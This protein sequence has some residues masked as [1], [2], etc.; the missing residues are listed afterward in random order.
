MPS[1]TDY[2]KSTKPATSQSAPTP[3][4]PAPPV[5]PEQS[6]TPWIEKFRP[7]KLDD[8]ACQEETIR[9]L[10]SSLESN[11]L[12]HLLFYGP[13][14]TGKTSTILAVARELYG[15]ELMKKRVLEL[16]ASDERG[17]SVVREKV[18]TF[19]QTAVGS[20]TV[21]GHPCPPFKIIILDE[22]DAMTADA[23]AALRRIIEQ[24][25]KVTR[26]CLICN[27]VSRIIDPLTSRC[28][29][30]RFRLLGKTTSIT[31]L[32]EIA[33]VEGLDV[34]SDV[35]SLIFDLTDGDLRRAVNLLQS[36]SALAG[37]SSEITRE[38][39]LSI[40]GLVPEERVT[41]ILDCA[42]LGNVS[43]MFDLCNGLVLDGIPVAQIFIHLEKFLTINSL[44]LSALKQASLLL[45]LSKCDAAINDGASELLQL[46]LFCSKLVKAV[47]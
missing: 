43:R 45:L 9:A 27:Y 22:A 20:E 2:F 23:Q 4:Q 29:K 35:L 39:V 38:S 5:E 30:F 19:A 11:N 41:C 44:G 16:N 10:R 6:K 13:P 34:S 12:P 47:N 21:K 17:I 26:F 18:K 8:I 40:A 1:I 25:S 7:K 28:A 14:G 24:Y 33:S 31:R 15:P 3:M 36:S 46:G 42:R 37:E 32:S